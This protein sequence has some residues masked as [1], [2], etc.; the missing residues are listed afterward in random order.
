[1]ALLAEGNPITGIKAQLGKFR[2]Q[3]DMM[4]MEVPALVI[5]AMLASI[6]VSFVYSSTPLDI[7]GRSAGFEAAA[8]LSV[9][10]GIMILSAWRSFTNEVRDSLARF[11]SML[12]PK[13]MLIACGMVLLALIVFLECCANLLFHILWHGF[14]TQPVCRVFNM[15]AIN[16]CRCSPAAPVSVNMKCTEWLPLVTLPTALFAFFDVFQV[17]IKRYAKALGCDFKNAG[18]AAHV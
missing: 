7:L 16:A 9:L 3:F 11:F 12:F 8:I 14:T 1:M 13:A 10:V 15:P 17:F 2:E 6:V 18:F 4:G 5:A